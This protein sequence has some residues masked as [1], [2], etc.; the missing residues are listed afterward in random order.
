M[1]AIRN[2]AAVL[3]VPQELPAS[4]LRE[5]PASLLRGLPASPSEC[6]TQPAKAIPS[7][8]PPQCFQCFPGQT[9]QLDL[10]RSAYSK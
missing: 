9:Q 2:P 10:E 1:A 7:S 8:A 5:L 3:P 6:W 4:L